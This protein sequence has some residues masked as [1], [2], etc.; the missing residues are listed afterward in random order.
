MR[1]RSFINNYFL[2][3][4]K[5]FFDFSYFV[6]ISLIALIFSI[7]EVL[8]S[9]I[10]WK[11]NAPGY[12]LSNTSSLGIINFIFIF[13]I[14]F[15]SIIVVSL[16]FR[17]FTNLLLFNSKKE[18]QRGIS[19]LLSLFYNSICFHFI[20]K[21]NFNINK[22]S[23][24]DKTVNFTLILF[25]IYSSVYFI[26]K[27]NLFQMKKNQ[28]TIFIT[29]ILIFVIFL[30]WIII[31][32]QKKLILN[33]VENNEYIFVFQKNGHNKDAIQTYSSLLS[34]SQINIS[35][36]WETFIIKLN[37]WNK[38][39][40]KKDSNSHLFLNNIGD[41]YLYSKIKEINSKSG[42]ICKNDIESLRRYYF[43]KYT[44]PLINFFPNRILVKIFP[45]IYCLNLNSSFPDIFM[46]SIY[47]NI[48]RSEKKDSLIVSFVNLD[49]YEQYSTDIKNQ[50][51]ILFNT[52]PHIKEHSVFYFLN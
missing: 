30:D 17:F 6:I 13:F 20:Y 27:N 15:I 38:L 11:V 44:I 26:I 50:L 34:S 19:I 24:T 16:L 40:P 43:L 10:T 21:Y 1:K 7:F 25:F 35:Y 32:S 46:Y 37:N 51:E 2:F 52:Y 28:K 14:C 8:Y 45:D 9:Y 29:F 5:F 49:S 4:M 42:Q 23:F 39:N 48:I 36:N 33:K 31:Y 41:R 22:I 47:S 18:I 12:Q 3:S